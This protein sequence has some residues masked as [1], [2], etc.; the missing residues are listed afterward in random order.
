MFSSLG[1]LTLLPLLNRTSNGPYVFRTLPDLRKSIQR[2]QSVDSFLLNL[3]RLVQSPPSIESCIPAMSVISSFPPQ[4]KKFPHP[5]QHPTPPPPPPPPPQPNT[6]HPPPPPPPPPT[7]PF[8]PKISYSTWILPSPNY[9]C[10]TAP[11]RGSDPVPPQPRLSPPQLPK[12]WSLSAKGPFTNDLF[13]LLLRCCFF[14]S[15][16]SVG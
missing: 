12:F 6:N 3:S 13:S 10:P 16:H 9:L 7:T 11:Y 2:K 4:D 1:S 14:L 5:P 15:H 8:Y